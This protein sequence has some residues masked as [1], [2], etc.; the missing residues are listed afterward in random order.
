[1]PVLLALKFSETKNKQSK[2]EEKILFCACRFTFGCFPVLVC[3]FE[4]AEAD[5]NAVL[6]FPQLAAEHRAKALLRRGTAR[7]HKSEVAAAAGDFRQVLALEPNNRQAREE[8]KVRRGQ[9]VYLQ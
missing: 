7:I 3:S 6:A 9:Q 5:C 1:L 8:L 2:N 4:A